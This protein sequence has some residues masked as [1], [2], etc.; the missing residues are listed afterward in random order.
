MK[1][2][3]IDFEPGTGLDSIDTAGVT[4]AIESAGGQESVL[5]GDGQHAYGQ[6][7]PPQQTPTPSTENAPTPQ[8]RD[9]L[10]RWTQQQIDEAR[11]AQQAEQEPFSNV[12]PDELPPE[13]QQIYRSLQGDYTRKT[14]QLAEQRKVFEQFGDPQ[15][16]AEAVQLQQQLAD[17]RYW[18]SIHQQ[19]SESLREMG[20][21]PQEA[22]SIANEQVAQQNADPLAGLDD[23]DLQ[24]V[25]EAY[26]QLQQEVQQ[27]RQ[28]LTQ[29]RESEQAQAL[30]MAV[31]GELQRQENAITQQN[32]HYTQDDIDAI[33]EMSTFYDGNLLQAQQRYEGAIQNRLSAYIAS[34]AGPG[35]ASP[36]SGSMV[37]QQ[38][39]DRPRT[40][41]EAHVAAMQAI[42][43][44][45][46]G[47]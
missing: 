24:P 36:V 32:P 26:T 12:N 40:L 2:R 21:S 7:A 14:Q 28:E 20:Y 37:T 10:G 46:A 33:Y 34:K 25:R 9:E 11:A 41:D 16:I 15:S 22:H 19:L 39:P 38:T 18:P 4:A 23:P 27:M 31:I 5:A 6:P 35:V 42:R 1:T 47:Q 43:L 13:L 45:E 8:P 17:P 29:Q 3:F 44:M 30:E